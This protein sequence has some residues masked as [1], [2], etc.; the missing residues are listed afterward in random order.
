MGKAL[1]RSLP[2]LFSAPVREELRFRDYLLI[3]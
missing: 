1:E 3:V 2:A